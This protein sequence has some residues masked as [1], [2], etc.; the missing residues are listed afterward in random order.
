MDEE[1]HICLADFS[2]AKYMRDQE[3]ESSMFQ[4][5]GSFSNLLVP[6]VDNDPSTDWWAL[7]AFV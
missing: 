1:G 7:G 5:F 6:E 4:S 3:S 2:L